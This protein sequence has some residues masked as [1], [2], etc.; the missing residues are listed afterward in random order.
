[1]KI[2]LVL[3]V[4][5]V[6]QLS[7]SVYSQN[8]RLSM[9]LN[10]MTL[11]DVFKEIRNQSEFTFVYDLEDVE[12]I[13]NLNLTPESATVEE[14]LDAC[15]EGTNLNYEVYEKVVI[16]K[17]KEYVA[18]KS[19]AQEKKSIKGK[20]TDDTGFALP[21]VSVVIKGTNIGV[22]TDIDGNYELE[23]EQENVVLV[24]SFVGM[25]PQEI[26]YN[27]QL[28]QNVSLLADTEQ[29]AE[30]V[31][32]GYQTIEKGRAT[33][34]FEILDNE[35][36]G[37]VASID[38][39]DRMKG[40]ASG[41]QVDD[42]GSITIRG[43]GSLRANTEP[44]I[45]VDGFPYNGSLN[46]INS[47]DI[48][49]ISVLKDAASTAIYGIKGANG[50]IVVTTKSGGKTDQL[51]I[52][53][54]STARFSE[55]PKYKDLG[56]MSAREQVDYT[57]GLYDEFGL[58][59][60]VYI[61]RKGNLGEVWQDQQNGD[62]TEAE[63]NELYDFYRTSNDIEKYIFERPFVQ[64]H[65]LSFRHG[66]EKN[67]FYASLSYDDQ[68]AMGNSVTE[69]Q[70][71][72]FTINDKL[73]VSK[74][75]DVKMNFKGIR[76]KNES[77]F[78]G[79]TSMVP[80]T[81][82]YDKD[83]E[84]LNEFKDYS[85]ER[86][87]DLESKGA[88]PYFLNRLQ[89]ARNTDIEN[90][91]NQLTSSM[92]V[93]LKPVKGVVWSNSYSHFVSYYDNTTFYDKKTSYA[94]Y[95]VNKY[96]TSTGER[97][98]PYGHIQK[99]NSTKSVS[100]TLRSQLSI[101]KTIKDFRIAVNAGVERNEFNT[102]TKLGNTRYNYDPQTLNQ[103]Q[104]KGGVYDG[105]ISLSGR[106]TRAYPWD[107]PSTQ[108]TNEKFTS[109]YF[110][111]SLSYKDK[112]NV[113]GS[114]RLDKTNLFGQSAKY[115]N[116]P[117]WSIG[118]KWNVSDEDFFKVDWI[119]QLS[120]KGSYGLA[121]NIERNTGPFLIIQNGVD[122]VTGL[123]NASVSNPANPLLGWEKSYVV[124]LGVDFR[125]FGNRLGG[126][127]EYYNKITK[128][129]LAKTNVDPTNG[130]ES[131][132]YQSFYTNNGEIK[133][134]GI[135]I[136]LFGTIVKK[137]D[138]SYDASLNLSYNYNEVRKLNL[139]A[140]TIQDLYYDG[141]YREGQ[142]VNYLPYFNS[143]LNDKGEVILID[144]EGT[145]LPGDQ[146][147]NIDLENLNYARKDP[148]V[149]GSMSHNFKYKNFSAGVFLTYEFGHKRR[150]LNDVMAWRNHKSPMP[151]MLLNSWEK[152]G[153]EKHTNIPKQLDEMYTSLN[154]FAGVYGAWNYTKA[155]IIRLK[156]INLS[157]DFSSYLKDTYIKGLVVRGTLENLWEW[158]AADDD[159]TS[160]IGT[161]PLYKMYTL[162]VNVKF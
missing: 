162:S 49:Q 57:L 108:E 97:L 131:K 43:V 96:T 142:P 35:D 130:Y 124:N 75:V 37:K 58:P 133:N 153:D 47:S 53:I 98:I 90:I 111:G 116:Q 92:S 78:S 129:V 132:W 18:P 99:E 139:T 55:M 115:R 135:D 83:G 150:M 128:D 10:N 114:W 48:D 19:E 25:T 81:R 147:Y 65:S 27:G 119:N 113:F 45:V 32:T 29:M 104:P 106:Y 93:D 154:D 64:K 91:T 112:Y 51:E 76:R 67:Q 82:F 2:T 95:E 22:A 80:Y 149:F 71:I 41:V 8:T 146:V 77:K 120:L 13:G 73:S 155:D 158:T 136:N 24:F 15:L 3:I 74:Y 161:F 30:V 122:G 38:L 21:G 151:K 16:I 42:D 102:L 23:F 141:N 100:K 70:N 7:A 103:S 152:A 52:E 72:S 62:I 123:P 88:L 85:D 86:M 87:K 12:H 39:T 34:S 1:M 5:S 44:L 60:N 156:S 9:E 134:T 14:I 61:S 126:S 6:L 127:V 50:V 31:V 101:N 117:S 160:A 4:V 17:E 69:N 140:Q 138:F 11:V 28:V 145:E 54:N 121:G 109:S 33:G 59:I 94:R 84:Y 66:T 68:N 107:L 40:I 118:S 157:Y 20:V 105:F 143:R 79:I 159:R 46:D 26:R 125:L 110:T 89:D 56:Y 137:A 36:L 148:S 63:A 144:K